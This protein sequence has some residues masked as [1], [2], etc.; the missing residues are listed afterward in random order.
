VLQG[1]DEPVLDGQQPNWVVEEMSLNDHVGGPLRL[2]LQL[3]SDEGGNYDGFQLDDLLVTATGLLAT[4]VDDA[5]V[6]NR[7][8]VHPQP[9][10][11]QVM[12][13][14][15]LPAGG[16]ATE[17]LLRDALGALVERSSM[18]GGQGTTAMNVGDLAPGVYHLSAVQQGRVVAQQRLVVMRP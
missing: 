3:R 6:M 15:S 11:D 5:S 18:Q 1:E 16:Q 8:L 9:A 14:V 12:V 13:S 2:R 4:G 10:T 17:L 7:M